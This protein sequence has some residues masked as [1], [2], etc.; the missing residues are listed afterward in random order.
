MVCQEGSEKY[1]DNSSHTL[2]EFGRYSSGME[3][4]RRIAGEGRGN[5]ILKLANYDWKLSLLVIHQEEG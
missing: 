4:A 5:L 2:R 3:L 1:W